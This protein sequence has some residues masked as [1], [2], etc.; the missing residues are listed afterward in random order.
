MRL[1][2]SVGRRVCSRCWSLLVTLL[3]RWQVPMGST[4]IQDVVMGAVTVPHS[5]VDD[6]VK[7][8]EE[9]GVWELCHL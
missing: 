8:E 4:V 2:V 7:G 1:K 9:G 5:V 3:V 6:Q